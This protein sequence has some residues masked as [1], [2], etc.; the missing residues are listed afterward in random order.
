MNTLSTSPSLLQVQQAHQLIA[1]VAEA[2]KAAKEW[3]DHAKALKQQLMDLHAAGVVPSEFIEAGYN[4]KL[5]QGRT[6][7]VLDDTTK[8]AIAELQQHAIATG[9]AIKKQGAAFWQLRAI[10]EAG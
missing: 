10:K 2:D 7:V 8:A 1:Q 6:S 3:A 5:Q 4:F 9:T